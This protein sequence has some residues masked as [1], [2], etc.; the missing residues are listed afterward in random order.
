MLDIIGSFILMQFL[1]LKSRN[2]YNLFRENLT[3]RIAICNFIKINLPHGDTVKEVLQNI[4][5]SYIEEIIILITKNL[6]QRKS[7]INFRF[8]STYRVVID[9]TGIGQTNDMSTWSVRKISKNGVETFHRSFV[10]ASLIGPYEF[11]IPLLWEPIELQDGSTKEDCELNASKRLLDKLKRKFPRLPITIIADGLY[12]SS[13]FMNIL[14]N[15]D[16]KFIITFKKGCAES[17]WNDF[18]NQ[19]VNDFFSNNFKAI[20]DNL[21]VPIGLHS[22]STIY[23]KIYWANGLCFSNSKLF[24]DKFSIISCEE[25]NYSLDNPPRVIDKKKHDKIHYM[26]ITNFLI[27]KENYLLIEKGGRERSIIEDGFNH[28]K[29]RGAQIKHK[30]TRNSMSLR[31]IYLSLT[32]LAEILEYIII[33]ST[34]FVSMYLTAKNTI[35]DTWDQLKWT[36][37]LVKISDDLEKTIAI[38]LPSQFSFQIE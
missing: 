15:F 28:S 19:Y 17:V 31:K 29:N 12:A 1:H 35:E 9:A 13:P 18:I 34:W 37:R 5:S 2:K 14:K 25:S 6:I 8:I 38:K 20:N 16:W 21:N 27:S 30:L 10:Q 26:Y 11:K 7:L 32:F 24:K 4:D 33:K 36:L 23:R 3:F 22:G